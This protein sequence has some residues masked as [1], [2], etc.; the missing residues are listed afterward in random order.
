MSDAMQTDTKTPASLDLWIEHCRNNFE[1]DRNFGWMIKC[2]ETCATHADAK[3]F[4]EAY[5]AA[6]PWATAY[7]NLD[8]MLDGFPEEIEGM[9]RAAL[10]EVKWAIE[11]S[12]DAR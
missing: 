2:A 5:A 11:A 7:G 6:L 8:Y 3:R 10:R 4:V 12:G 9:F 1:P